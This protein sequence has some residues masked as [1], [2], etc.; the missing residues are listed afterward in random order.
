MRA[1]QVVIL[2]VLAMAAFG[3]RQ[4]DAVVNPP[5][6]SSAK[7]AYIVGEGG[8][9]GGASLSYYDAEHDTLFRSVA[10]AESSWRFPN[11][12]KIAGT[13][14]YIAVSGSDR[15]EVLDLTTH[16]V[17]TSIPLPGGSGP[18]FLAASG[19]SLY[20]AN[21][22]GTVS[23]I[24]TGADSLSNTS[25]RVVG[26]PGGIA[27]AGGKVFVAD[28]GLYPAVGEWLKVLDAVGLATVDSVHVGGG[29]AQ[30]AVAHGRLFVV[31]TSVSRVYAVN[32]S[33]LA[34]EDSIQMGGFL[35]DIGT[36]G[37]ALF[38]LG[39]DSVAKLSATPLGIVTN[40]LVG[41]SLGLYFYSLGV[42]PATGDLYLGTV[43]GSAGSGVLEIYS[44]AGV[45]LRSAE[46]CGIFPG[47]YAF[48]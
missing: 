16:Q 6:G 43:T 42:D 48:R 11:D 19:T 4:S 17:V 26:F 12:M 38:V 10:A 14:G 20:V 15:V 45:R 46:S 41:R 18:G 7:G 47:A 23:R 29:P 9:T 44:G 36:D 24:A 1:H 34:V 30:M 3:C 22:D 32:P 8:F 40:G 21:Y 37:Q 5:P 31:A 35:S 2:C 25:V 27:V 13:R 28:V 33:T 39:S